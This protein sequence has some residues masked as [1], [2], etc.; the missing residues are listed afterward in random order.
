MRI[1]EVEISN[2]RSIREQTLKFNNK[3]LILVGK[4]EAG[5]TNILKAI[6]GGLDE[7]AYKITPKD[8]RKRLSDEHFDEKDFYIDYIF[9]LED[10]ELRDIYFNILEKYEKLQ[11]VYSGKRLSI[12]D[13]VLKYFSSGLWRYNIV[14]H[15]GKAMY[16]TLPKDMK[17]SDKYYIVMSEFTDKDNVN[18][19]SGA[20]I[21]FSND[22]NTK[23]LIYDDIKNEIAGVL[24]EYIKNN[25]PKVYFWKY[26]E[27]YLLPSSVDIDDFKSN[28]SNYKP[29]QNIFLLAGIRDIEKEFDDTL[30]EDGHYHNLLERVSKIV[31]DNFTK[32]WKDLKGLEITLSPDGD[33]IS[34][35]VKEAVRYNFED[36]SD[37][38]KKFISILLML[39]TEVECGEIENSIILIDEPDNS[40]YPTGARY[41]KNTLINLSNK[42]MVV[43]STHSPF[44]I[45]KTNIGRHIIVTKNKYDITELQV[46]TESKYSSDEV[47][48]NAIGTSSF[49]HLKECN[50]IFEG[51]SDCEFFLKAIHSNRHKEI[52]LNFK[53]VG[54]AYSHGCTSIEHIT[55]LLMLANKNIVIF[56]DSDKP[57]MDA[58][59]KYV[60]SEGYQKDNWHTFSELG[61]DKDETIEDYIN[62][63]DLLQTALES[64]GKTKDIRT[65]GTQKIMK[66]VSDLTRDEKNDFKTF[67]I[68]NMEDKD[69]KE[70]YFIRI[71]KTLSDKLQ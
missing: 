43:Y 54:A 60:E 33:N 59:K 45:D 37:G 17:L 47:L 48:L 20:V 40:L 35:Q 11:F 70:E 3:C 61:G 26:T 2:F 13:F 67:I 68:K 23:E 50:I 22:D 34:I 65:R 69:I 9:S 5:K 42:N 14:S 7:K 32:K 64:I 62:N 57:S 18:Y 19:S 21:N 71:L 8:K 63:D 39:S 29:L 27:D 10:A 24:L 28:P 58:K 44:M 38:F 56:T 25:L 6:A 12:Y 30:E 36:R 66:F 16:Y 31:T 4:N 53:N 55:P 15:S 52:T 46:A 41:L 51:W 1:K 49:E